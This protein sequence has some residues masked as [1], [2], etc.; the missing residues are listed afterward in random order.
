MGAKRLKAQLKSQNSQY[1]WS[2]KKDKKGKGKCRKASESRQC[3][4]KK[5]YK[6]L[7]HVQSAVRLIK[8]PMRYYYCELCKGYHLTRSDFGDFKVKSNKDKDL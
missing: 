1:S 6:D 7:K 2:G 8:V 4:K 3:K 5:R